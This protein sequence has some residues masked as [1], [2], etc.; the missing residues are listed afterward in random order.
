M[1]FG[2]EGGHAFNEDQRADPGCG[3][4]Y[5]WW[6]VYADADES[7][8]PLAV[9]RSHKD[10]ERWQRE[11]ARHGEIVAVPPPREKRNPVQDTDQSVGERLLA[12]CKA[13]RATMYSDKSEESKLADAAIAAAEGHTR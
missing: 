6:A 1:T 3:K 7:P 11:N 8:L 13:M 2:H 9:F 10:A 5:L 12:A 4:D